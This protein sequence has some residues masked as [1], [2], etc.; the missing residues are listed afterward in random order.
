MSY[1]GV[2][3]GNG[4]HHPVPEDVLH[5]KDLGRQTHPDTGDADPAISR[6]RRAGWSHRSG[7]L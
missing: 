3:R 6:M 5:Y 1:P 7:S 4:I 2:T